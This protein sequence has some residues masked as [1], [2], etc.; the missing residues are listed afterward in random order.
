[1]AYK[2]VIYFIF[3]LFN[4]AVSNSG[5]IASNDWIAV[6]SELERIRKNVVI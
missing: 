4:D 6:N 2:P 1:M 3:G 5:C